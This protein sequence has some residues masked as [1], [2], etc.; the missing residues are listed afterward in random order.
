[1]KKRNIPT[2]YYPR[3]LLTRFNFHFWVR[4]LSRR[5]KVVHE[6]VHASSAPCVRE[7]GGGARVHTLWLCLPFSFQRSLHE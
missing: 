5:S 4:T 7:K 2:Y 1:M 6:I 3:S